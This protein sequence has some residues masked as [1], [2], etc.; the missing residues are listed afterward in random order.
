MVANLAG[1]DIPGCHSVQYQQMTFASKKER[2]YDMPNIFGIAD[3]ILIVGYDR[4]G[5]DN[6]AILRHVMQRHRKE[7]LK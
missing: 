1:I 6:D 4:I 7:N 2:S 3:E 5:H